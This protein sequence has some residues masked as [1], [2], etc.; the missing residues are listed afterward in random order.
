MT[1]CVVMYRQTVNEPMHCPVNVIL[2]LGTKLIGCAFSCLRDSLEIPTCALL[3]HVET[4][5]ALAFPVMT[6][7]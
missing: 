1:Q 4:Q 2:C 6:V 5:S 7:V 3:Y